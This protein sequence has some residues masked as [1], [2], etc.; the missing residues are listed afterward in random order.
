[1]AVDSATLDR[2]TAGPSPL[3]ALFET[4]ALS[5][6]VQCLDAASVVRLSRASRGLRGAL[7]VVHPVSGRRAIKVAHFSLDRPSPSPPRAL[8][9]LH[10]ASLKSLTFRIPEDGTYAKHGKDFW[11]ECFVLLTFGLRDCVRLESFAADLR[12]F[13]E[14]EGEFDRYLYDYF[15]RNLRECARLKSLRIWNE[16]AP[17]GRR[18]DRTYYSPGFL[19]ALAPTL[20]AR[21][22]TLEE[23]YLLFGDVPAGAEEAPPAWRGARDA[24]AVELF[25]SVVALERLRDLSVQMKLKTSAL[26]NVL[27]FVAETTRRAGRALPSSG[28][29]RAFS[30]TCILYRYQDGTYG[31]LPTPLPVAPLL[32]LIAKADLSKLLLRVPNTCWDQDGMR[33]LS[34]CLTERKPRPSL[35]GLYFHRYRPAGGKFPKCILDYVESRE[36]CANNCIIVNGLHCGDAEEDE[37]MDALEKYHNSE[38]AQCLSFSRDDLK[39]GMEG[40]AQFEVKGP[41]MRW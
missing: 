10:W 11:R 8:F 18:S 36:G 37:V 35:I 12:P 3:D 22:S 27:L 23:L 9:D 29:L 28:T 24:E 31:P 14:L 25:E 30:L 7:T 33:E 13:H 20:R 21:A 15:A 41:M 39:P 1:M 2:A 5:E 16:Y 19:R 38:G 40:L 17:W 6:V 26:L 4:D 34:R 32:A